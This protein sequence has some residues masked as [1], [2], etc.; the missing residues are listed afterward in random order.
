MTL[1]KMEQFRFPL[2]RTLEFR[3]L[4]EAFIKVVQ[5]GKM[6]FHKKKLHL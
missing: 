6:K 1:T 2:K 3:D 5:D 4:V